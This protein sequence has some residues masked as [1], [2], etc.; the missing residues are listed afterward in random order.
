M[1]PLTKVWFW[2]LL[3]SIV[4]FLLAFGF[5]EGFGQT[6]TDE[7]ETPVWI[8]VLF[9][10][11]FFFWL[12]AAILYG[13]EYAAYK[14]AVA[15]GLIDPP[16]KTETYDCPCDTTDTCVTVPNAPVPQVPSPCQSPQPCAQVPVAPCKKQVT[17]VKDVGTPPSVPDVKSAMSK[18]VTVASGSYASM[19]PNS[20]MTSTQVPLPRGDVINP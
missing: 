13:M 5:F 19:K 1:N 18:K 11:A 9:G 4:L 12:A 16:V 10:I 15:C 7:T 20:I 17:V 8:W 14:K 6:N 2:L 3:I